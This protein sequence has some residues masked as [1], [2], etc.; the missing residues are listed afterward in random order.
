MNSHELLKFGFA[1]FAVLCTAWCLRPL[2]TALAQRLGA[3]ST[4][5][6]EADDVAALRAELLDEVHHVRHELGELAERVDFTERLL[7]KQREP[8]AL[9]PPRR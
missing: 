4:G 6:V 2:V 5:T 8:E 1:A 9:P 7:A 3:G